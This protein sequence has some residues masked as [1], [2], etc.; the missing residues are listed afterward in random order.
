MRWTTILLAAAVAVGTEASSLHPPVLP[1][2]V[3][4]PYLSTWLGGARGNP[5]DRWPI[6]WTGQEVCRINSRR[7]VGGLTRPL[8]WILRSCGCAKVRHSLSTRRQAPRLPAE[9]RGR[10]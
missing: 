4:N 6:F 7:Q 8:D 2:F 3:R 1:L 10:V 9:E 5:W